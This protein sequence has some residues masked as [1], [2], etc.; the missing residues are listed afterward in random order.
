MLLQI[1]LENSP[2]SGSI[3]W[4]LDFP[5]CFA[6]GK[7]GPE[8]LVA[9][10]RAFLQYA[11]WIDRHTAD[12]W[13]ADL[14]DFDLRLVETFECYRITA[15]FDRAS[16]GQGGEVGAWFRHDWKPLADEDVRRGLLMLEWSRADL[17]AG[18]SLL[19][20]EQQEQEHPGEGWSINGILNHLGETEWGYLENL[21]HA[22][23]QPAGI[24]Q[25]PED[26][27]AQSRSRL[28]A[29]LPAWV[30]L[31]LVTGRAGEF[32]SPR[33]VL[34]RALWHELDHTE[35]IRKLITW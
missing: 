4:A 32:W 33:K 30:G 25:L 6:R 2:E 24:S 28:R 29:A 22:G 7:D 11:G 5:G 9:M 1:G 35:Q 27:L 31:E 13:L 12:S 26:L 16:A 34:R 14:G 3:A 17:L 19:T 10:P 23:P 15:T 21:G 18:L 20:P 8:A